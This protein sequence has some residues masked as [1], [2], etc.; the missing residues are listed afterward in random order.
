MLPLIMP[1]LAVSFGATAPFLNLSV[2][3]PPYSACLPGSV[4]SHLQLGRSSPPHQP[5]GKAEM[6]DLSPT[7]CRGLP[8][9]NPGGHWV[10]GPYSSLQ[11]PPG[12]YPRG[13]RWLSKLRQ[14]LLLPDN[15]K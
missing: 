8:G 5:P 15:A 12:T 7:G 9:L 6:S 4:I 10:R 1:L 14:G 3:L 2:P 11:I 13:L